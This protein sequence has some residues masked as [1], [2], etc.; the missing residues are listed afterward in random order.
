MDRL[1]LDIAFGLR[2]FALDVALSIGR[3]TLALVGPSGA[4]K[5]TVLR[6]V[7]GLRRPDS[8][9]IALGERAWFDG[10]AGIDL[11]PERA[12]SGSSSRSTRSFRT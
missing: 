12:R 8:G 3:E 2:S 4:G 6:A 10:A 7:A 1:E 5:T 9:R 11:P